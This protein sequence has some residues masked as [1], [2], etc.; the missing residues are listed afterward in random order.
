MPEVT[1]INLDP[2]SIDLARHHSHSVPRDGGPINYPL[3]DFLTHPFEKNS[4]DAIVS[5]AALHH[6]NAIAALA[7]MR[8]LLR[9]GGTLAIIELARTQLPAEPARRTRRGHRYPRSQADQDLLGAPR[10]DA[11]ATTAH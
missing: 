9:P 5:V 3:A 7:R 11:L 6:M 10:T 4:F 1:A 2:A 8:E